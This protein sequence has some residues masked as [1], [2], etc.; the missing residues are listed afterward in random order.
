MTLFV[1]ESQVRRTLTW[2][3][4]CKRSAARGQV[5]LLQPELRSSSTENVYPYRERVEL[6]RSSGWG[7]AVLP[8]AALHLHGVIHVKVLRTKES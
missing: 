2:I 1:P 5:T 7:E 4:P 3:T 6:L 8:R